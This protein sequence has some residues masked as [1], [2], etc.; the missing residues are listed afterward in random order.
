MAVWLENMASESCYSHDSALTVV[1][2]CTWNILESL[3][4][5]SGMEL[6]STAAPCLALSLLLGTEAI[7]YAHTSI[8]AGPQ[9]A[10]VSSPEVDGASQRLM[11][12]LD[13]IIYCSCSFNI[14]CICFLIFKNK[15][16]VARVTPRHCY[17]H[18]GSK[19]V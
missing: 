5:K 10:S 4:W 18:S 11:L 3:Q 13:S 1:G 15:E 14:L 6:S 9:E 16:C 8:R 19:N 17:E 7:P 2:P 12:N